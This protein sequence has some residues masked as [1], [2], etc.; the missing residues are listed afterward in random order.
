MKISNQ[1]EIDKVEE[2]WG[3]KNCFHIVQEKYDKRKKDLLITYIIQ[4][5][6]II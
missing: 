2:I 4:Q 6:E 1:K 3:V 5:K